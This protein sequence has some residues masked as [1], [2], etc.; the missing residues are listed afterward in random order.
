MDVFYSIVECLRYP[1]R[2]DVDIDRKIIIILN[3]Y[4][5]NHIEIDFYLR[6]FLDDFDAIQVKETMEKYL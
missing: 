3:K 6:M 1:W 5:V 4:M 2:R